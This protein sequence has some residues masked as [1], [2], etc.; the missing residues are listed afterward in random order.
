[1]A[2]PSAL[3]AI[4][5]PTRTRI[6]R[7]ILSAPDGRARVGDLAGAVGL[8][9]P[10]VTH[11]LRTLLAVGVVDR[12]AAG[13]AAW[14]SIDPA[15]SDRVASLVGGEPEPAEPDLERIAAD[16]ATRFRGVFG[17]ETVDAYV[18]E[19]RELLARDGAAPSHLSSRTAAFAASRLEALATTRSPQRGRPEVLFVCVQNAGR[20]QL[21]AAI[22][23]QLAGDRVVVR[24]AGSRPATELRA[25]IAAVLDEIGVPVGGEFPKPLTDEAVRA[26]DHVVTMGCGDACPVH[27]GRRYLDWDVDDPAGAPISRVRAIRDEIEHRVRDLLD[28]LL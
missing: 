11:H 5:D 14:F 27:P 8:R 24:T 20:S 13:R 19:S 16:L 12:Q 21:A 1:M 15:W 3:A 2:S 28:E 26:A 10:T 25:T 4:A 7:L 18:R 22:L 17:R 9:Q 23:R 6:L